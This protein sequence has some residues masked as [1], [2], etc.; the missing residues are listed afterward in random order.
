[1]AFAGSSVW[2]S[3]ECALAC[4]LLFTSGTS[5]RYLGSLA[6][7]CLNLSTDFGPGLLHAMLLFFS[8]L[9]SSLRRPCVPQLT[10]LQQVAS[11]LC[12]QLVFKSFFSRQVEKGAHLW[13]RRCRGCELARG[14]E[15]GQKQVP[16]TS[17]LSSISK[18]SSNHG[19]TRRG[20][21]PSSAGQTGQQLALG[22]AGRP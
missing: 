3:N 16:S 8:L 10:Q 21:A 1:M 9:D 18:H 2:G 20:P 15:L 13:C 19:S 7:S 22:W 17:E 5:E 4:Q 14:H 6:L 11:S 12:K